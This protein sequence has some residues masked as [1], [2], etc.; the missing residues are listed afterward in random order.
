MPRTGPISI[1][2]VVLVALLACLAGAAR[3]A[4]AE[5]A[6]APASVQAPVS[7]APVEPSGDLAGPVRHWLDENRIADMPGR[8]IETTVGDADARLRLAPCAHVQ[9]SLPPGLRLWGRTRLAAHCADGPTHWTVYVPVTVK[10]WTAGLVAH[11]ALTAGSVLTPNDLSVGEVDLAEDGGAAWLGAAGSLAGRILQR[12]IAAGQALRSTHL[13]P[14]VW[15]AA[16]DVV[17][18]LAEGDGFSVSGEGVAMTAGVEGQPARVRT[19]GGRVLTGN[20][21]AQRLIEM[22]L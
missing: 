14:R 22:P 12:P 17:K 5:S 6:Q 7:A 3:P 13:K 15:F 8:R 18:V 9:V 2:R 10:V 11:A 1:A 16:G 21:T 20:A 4:T 19:E